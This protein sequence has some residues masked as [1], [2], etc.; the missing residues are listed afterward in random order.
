MRLTA[1]PLR[2]GV[3]TAG[4]AEPRRDNRRARR[5][6]G[7]RQFRPGD[8]DGHRLQRGTWSKS[9]IV[10][11]IAFAGTY[12]TRSRFCWLRQILQAD[13]GPRG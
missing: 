6:I 10:A 11:G 7:H 13:Q 4:A 8:M 9:Q 1:R 3:P 5:E 2:I 12:G